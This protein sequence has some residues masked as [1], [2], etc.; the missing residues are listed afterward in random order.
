MPVV[1][2]EIDTEES[3]A[4]KHKLAHGTVLFI[5]IHFVFWWMIHGEEA[6]ESNSA[7]PV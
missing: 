7:A 2:S 4:D 3:R 5:F 1:K 6:Q